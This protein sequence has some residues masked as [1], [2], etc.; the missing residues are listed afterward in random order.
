MT[1]LLQDIRYAVRLTREGAGLRARRRADDRPRHRRQHRDLQRGPRGPAA[2]AAVSRAGPARRPAGAAPH[3]QMG[4][5]WP[6]FLD[7]REQRAFLENWRDPE[8]RATSA[9]LASRSAAGAQ[10]SASFFPLLGVRAALGRTFIESDDRPGAP[11]TMIFRT[12]SGGRGSA[13]TLRSRETGAAR[14]ESLH[15]RGRLAARLRVLP[16]AASTFTRRSASTAPN[17]AGSTAGTTWDARARPA[18][19]RR[20][21]GRPRE[22]DGS[23][24][25]RAGVPATPTADSR[26]LAIS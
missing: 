25:T 23:C 2:A 26:P 20:T 11:R 4:V 24:G 8:D 22:I 19:P 18:V 1:T 21:L 13:R 6:T 3:G 12:R 16:R 14:R 7:W 9:G 5:A 17:R 15:G 10:V